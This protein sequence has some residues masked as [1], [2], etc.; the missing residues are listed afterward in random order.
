MFCLPGQ[1][2]WVVLAFHGQLVPFS[3][4]TDIACQSYFSRV[5]I[6]L[7]LFWCFFVVFFLFFFFSF[8]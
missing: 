7:S 3:P 2:T 5:K 1:F 8:F 4:C 6:L